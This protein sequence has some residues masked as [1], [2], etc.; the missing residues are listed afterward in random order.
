[1]MGLKLQW[2]HILPIIFLFVL[3]SLTNPQLCRLL[4][5][6][7]SKTF[8]HGLNWPGLFLQELSSFSYCQNCSDGKS[9][10]FFLKKSWF[11]RKFFPYQMSDR[12]I[13]F[14]CYI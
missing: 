8:I 10:Q 11:D 5:F 7:N 13:Y 14:K 3:W 12:K 6:M 4:R 2:G 1:M 9:F